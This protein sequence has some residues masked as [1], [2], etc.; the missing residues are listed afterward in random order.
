[1]NSSSETVSTQIHPAT[2]AVELQPFLVEARALVDAALDRILPPESDVPAR[3]HAAIRWS[4]FAGGKRFRP[5][6][7]LAV[8]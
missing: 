5:I 8:G 4:V 3:T 2:G 1:M 7:L 6:L